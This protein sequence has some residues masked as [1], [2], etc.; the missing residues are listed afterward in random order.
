M[1]LKDKTR[2]ERVQHLAQSML[3]TSIFQWKLGL[4]LGSIFPTG[5]HT[6][7]HG[8]L[9]RLGIITLVW[10]IPA[11]TPGKKHNVITVV[12]GQWSEGVSVRRIAYIEGALV[13]GP[14]YTR[15]VADQSLKHFPAMIHRHW[16][17]LSGTAWTQQ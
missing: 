3:A 8:L 16:L 15:S 17:I 9:R 1:R 14:G 7:T 13:N 4:G 5:T 12:L 11:W 10:S 2:E 6:H